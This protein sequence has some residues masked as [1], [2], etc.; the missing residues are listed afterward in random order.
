MEQ[1][2]RQMEEAIREGHVISIV[3]DDPCSDSDEEDEATDGEEMQ[4]QQCLTWKT[5]NPP[6]RKKA[7]G[8]LQL[9]IPSRACVP[10]KN[11]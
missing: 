8:H 2:R 9:R 6:L 1:A 3:Y 4:K 10:R 7:P 5:L 11:A